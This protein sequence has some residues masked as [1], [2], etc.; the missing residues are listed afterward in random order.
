MTVATH[1][2]QAIV[3]IIKSLSHY[4]CLIHSL[5]LYSSLTHT[6]LQEYTHSIFTTLLDLTEQKPLQSED[7]VHRKQI[8]G[9]VVIAVA[10]Q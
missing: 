2:A 7:T 9:S 8:K 10:S 3:I 4:D 1:A 5:Q 6:D